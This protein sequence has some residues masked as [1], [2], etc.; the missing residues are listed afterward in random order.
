MKIAK[1]RGVRIATEVSGKPNKGTILLIMGAT[2]S[3]VWWPSTLVEQLSSAGYQVIRYD[4]RD[5]GKSTTNSP[6]DVQYGL[7]DLANDLLSVLDAYVLDSA[8]FVGMSLGGYLAQIVALTHP[9]RAQS[10]TLIA[11]E[12]LGVDYEA[13]GIAPE[14]MNHFGKMAE[15]DWTDREA[16]ADFMLG[17]SRLSAGRS[18]PF[19]QSAAMKRIR[20]ELDHAQNMQSAFNHSAIVGETDPKLNAA[21]LKQPTLIIHGTEDPIISVNAALRTA[22]SVLDSKLLLLEGRGHELP[23]RDIPKIVQSILDHIASS[24][25]ALPS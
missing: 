1:N 18:L 7:N 25:A 21:M 17:I 6:G 10:I 19:D 16:V 12:P 23:D 20:L 2:A 13:A 14:F 3:M 15:L 24:Q 5:T 4:H 9:A 8:H 11:A 22:A